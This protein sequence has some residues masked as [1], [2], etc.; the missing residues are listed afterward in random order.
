MNRKR[1]AIVTGIA[2]LL[3]LV[4]ST[5]TYRYLSDKARVAERARLQTV[6]IAVAVVD[7]P[8]GSTINS[9]QIA[10]TAWPKDHYPRDAVAEPGKAVGRVVRRDFLRGEPVTE[11]KLVPTDKGSS[12]LSLKVPVGKRAFSVKVNEV[13]GVGGFIVPDSRVDVVVT[14]PR[15]DRGSDQVAKTVLMDVQVLAA[16]QAIEQ[17]DNKP[18]TVNTVTLAVDPEEAEKLALASNDGK[19]Q[20]VLRNFTDTEKVMTSGVDKARLLASYRNPPPNPA[21]ERSV[22]TTPRTVRRAPPPVRRDYVVEVIRGSKRSEEKV[23]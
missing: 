6:G 7:I 13:V 23:D 15:S 12:I 22:R 21:P 5:A 2:L 14:I 8:L 11:S 20:L 4:A 17:T 3:A 18:V 1:I 10:L 9:N 16:G 19:I